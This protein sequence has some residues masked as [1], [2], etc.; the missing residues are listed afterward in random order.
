M[1]ADSEEQKLLRATAAK[2]LA[3]GD[4]AYGELIALGLL[5][6]GVDAPGTSLGD[7]LI[8]HEEIG[9]R[10]AALPYLVENAA[11]LVLVRLGVE[12]ARASLALD[13]QR[14]MWSVDLSP[15]LSPGPT[16]WL[17][18]ASAARA[19]LVAR[20]SNTREMVVEVVPAA[21]L[22]PQAMATLDLSFPLHE[23]RPPGSWSGERIAIVDQDRLAAILDEACAFSCAALCAEMVGS[24][25]QCLAEAIDHLKTR[26]Q[27]GQTIGS[28]QALQ[29]KAADMAIQLEGMRAF[30]SAL[31]APGFVCTM[32]NPDLQMAKAYIS[33]GYVTIAETCLQLYG[34]MGYS[35]EHSVHRRLRH[36]R[37]AGQ[38]LGAPSALRAEHVRSLATE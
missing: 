30:V 7:A 10:L 13:A 28:F 9:R 16:G 36:A 24:A 8:V 25:E 21:A 35:W 22:M 29:H 12:P 5:G 32:A 18:F 17:A 19:L 31:A 23:L 33:D 1:R 34:G 6:L 3:T 20:P 37:R 4:G 26:V 2:L 27:F 14:L 15:G 11:R 38:M